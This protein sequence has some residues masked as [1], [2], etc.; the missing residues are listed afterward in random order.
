MPPTSGPDVVL[1]NPGG[2]ARIYQS[3]AHQLA[4]CEPPVWAGLMAS[5]VRGKGFGAAVLDADAEGLSPAETAARVADMKPRLVAV[6]VYG[7]QPSAS[8]QTMP[9]AGEICR[10]VKDAAPALPV[11]MV[12]GHAASLPE[13]TLTEEAADYVCGGEGPVTIVELL[14]V[15]GAA[16][17]SPDLAAVR[18]LWY[19]DEGKPRFTKAAPLITA[20]DQEMPGPAWDL[21]PMNRYRAHNWHCLDGSP[22]EP[23]VA[24]YTTLGCPYKCSFC[25]IQAPFKSGERELGLKAAVNSYRFWSPEGVVD[26]LA[27]LA[28]KHGVRNVKVADEM[29]V[30]NRRHVERICDLIIERGL[31]LNCWAYARVDTVKD[32]MLEK[33]KKAGFHWLAFGIEAADS[34]VRDDVQKGYDQDDIFETIGKTR[35]A[36]IHVIGNYIFGL[37]EDDLATMQQTLDLALELNCEFGNF[38]C[39][40]AYPGSPLYRTAVANGWRLP[41][42]WAGYSQHSEDTL[43]L[44]TRHLSA[45]EVLRFRD[46]AF[47]TYYKAPR[48]LE[49]VERTFGREAVGHIQDMTSRRLVRKHAAAAPP[50]P[51]PR[52]AAA[53]V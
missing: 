40:M 52:P 37:P 30:L 24:L 6:V 14:R 8:T 46:E 28:E 12:G 27:M 35:A 45:G 49:M 47:L 18:D 15:L 7:H 16:G 39:A 4:A 3:L 20:L 19:R 21:L 43:P 17:G 1:V 10:A 11:L 31:D 29:F 33:L 48:Y 5:Y 22:R 42:T 25:C 36:G 13:R 9:A 26:Q 23:Y 41:D 51:A 34:K 32:G 50:T 53:P 2:R 44:P 38:Y